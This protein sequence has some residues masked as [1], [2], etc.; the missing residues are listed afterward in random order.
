MESIMIHEH[1]VCYM[2]DSWEAMLN[3]ELGEIGLDENNR[4]TPLR[5]ILAPEVGDDFIRSYY[6]II[7]AIEQG[8][9]YTEDTKEDLDN[10]DG[11]GDVDGPLVGIAET[12]ADAEE[13]TGDS[14]YVYNSNAGEWID[15][16]ESVDELE[17]RIS[18]EIDDLDI[19]DIENLRDE[20]DGLDETIGDVD[21]DSDGDLQ[22]QIEAH[23][24]RIAENEQDIGDVDVDSDGDLQTQIETLDAADISYD[25]DDHV[26]SLEEKIKK[27]DERV[28]ELISPEFRV[29]DIDV[30]TDFAPRDTEKVSATIENVGTAEG[31]VTAEL[32]ENWSSTGLSEDLTISADDH[33]GVEFDWQT[34]SH[35]GTYVVTV[36][37]GDDEASRQV[38]LDPFVRFDSLY[39]L[40]SKEESPMSNTGF[41]IHVKNTGTITGTKEI[42]ATPTSS[43][44]SSGFSEKTE[45]YT[46]DPDEHKAFWFGWRAW[47]DSY[48]GTHEF[49]VHT[50][51]DSYDVKLEIPPEYGFGNLYQLNKR[52][53]PPMSNVGF[54]VH[55]ENIG[56][57]TATRTITATPIDTTAS[58]GFDENTDEYTLDPGESQAFWMGWRAWDDSYIGTHT[59]EVHTE[60]DSFE[61]DL[62]VPSE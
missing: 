35:A 47:D 26:D 33:R 39:Q 37:A 25:A 30:P 20:L 53:E 42:T 44:A 4:E 60:Y 41:G 9:V 13:L 52:E 32:L 38:E 11:L 8:T 27:L 16:F 21:V 14:V 58:S 23:T 17:K 34:P 56:E 2:S 40:N 45:E 50:E 5:K 31:V 7:S 22:T 48:V 62:E 55:V 3:D 29:A 54:G 19:T 49:E 18:G 43:T 61:F 51:D 12:Q 36:Q 6:Q 28:N 24:D 1:I 46:L 59:F 10:K 15:T 57:K